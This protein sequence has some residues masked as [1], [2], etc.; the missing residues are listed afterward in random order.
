MRKALGA[1]RSRLVRQVLTESVLLSSLG[2]ILGML[3]ARWGSTLLVRG[4]ATG[5]EQVSLDLAIDRRILGFTAGVALFT[6]LLVGLLPALRST[7]VSL[8]AAMKGSQTAEEER[9]KRFPIGKSIVGAQLALSFTLLIGGGLL[10][11]TFV[12]LLTLDIGFAPGNVLL[13]NA[14]LRFANVPVEQRPSMHEEI[15]ARLRHLPGVKSVSRSWT[16]PLSRREWDQILHTD[17]PNA[18][19]GDQ[20]LVFLNFIS[21]SYFE[22]M[23]TPMISG[24]G[25]NDRDTSNSIPVAIVNQTLARRF[26][27]GVDP[28]GRTFYLE[29]DPGRPAPVIEIVGVVKDAKYESMREDMP[30]TAFFPILQMRGDSEN[31][32]EYEL[33]TSIPPANLIPAVQKTIGTVNKEIP[34]EFYSLAEQ[35]DESLVR[36][37][38]LATLSSFFSALALILAMIGLYGVLSYLV[39]QRQAEFGIRMALGARRRSVLGLVISDVLVIL[40]GGLSVGIGISLACT[41]LLQKMLFGL[42]AHDPSTMVIA[43]CALSAV[44][45]LA[46]GIPA[47]R[48]SRIDPMIA[49]RYE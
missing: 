40:A 16:T 22:T 44:T 15:A 30:A 32:S 35:V 33:R 12:K 13:V 48:A 46:G 3:F 20:A 39:T 28:I 21:P 14:S 24:R 34:L 38:L 25:F 31:S 1:S 36:E 23:R 42:S 27:P 29:S 4:L 43:I 49:L 6:G 45:I 18:P 47:W 9:R 7:S 26:F 41:H 8:M 10:L 37:R 19:T 17:S 2:A 11:R 5:A